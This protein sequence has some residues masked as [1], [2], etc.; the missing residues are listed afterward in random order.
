M[1]PAIVPGAEPLTGNQSSIVQPNKETYIVPT[2]TKVVK[3][4]VVI[5]SETTVVK[6]TLVAPTE[7]TTVVK[8]TVVAP[9]E[10]TTVVKETLVAPAEETTVVKETV[11]EEN[12]IVPTES[13]AIPDAVVV[14]VQ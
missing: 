6:E 8:E 3:E 1:I 14:P 4:T 9:A 2:E 11:K 12:I 7:A 10:Q 13:V 5:P